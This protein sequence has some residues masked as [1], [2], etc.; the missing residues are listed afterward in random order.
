MTPISRKAFF[1]ESVTRPLEGVP[2][3]E[4][5][6]PGLPLVRATNESHNMKS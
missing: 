1:A 5:T 6:P 2:A 3:R 4:N